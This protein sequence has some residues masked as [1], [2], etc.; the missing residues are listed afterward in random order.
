VTRIRPKRA[1]PRRRKA[2]RWTADDWENATPVL[3]HRQGH[4]CARCGEPLADHVERHHRQRREVGGDRYANLI[5]LHSHC[6]AWAHA[7][8][9]EARDGA[10]LIVSAH[11]PDPAEVPI[12]LPGL[13]GWAWWYLDD[14]GGQRPMP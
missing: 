12:Y 2:P 11:A 1:T 13:T 4:R 14:K 6:H 3:L 9:T 5:L 10:G 7:H 8:P